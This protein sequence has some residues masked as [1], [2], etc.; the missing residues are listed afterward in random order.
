[1]IHGLGDLNKKDKEEKKKKTNDYYAGGQASGLAV[2]SP[3]VSGIVNKASKDSRPEKNEV[4]I[5]ITLFSNGF[6]VNDGPFRDY[7]APENRAFMADINQGRVPAEL[8]SMTR[9]RPVAVSLQDRRSEEYQLPPPPK[10]V[11]FSGKGESVAS[12]Q[13][14]PVGTVN[15]NAPDPPFEASLPSTTVR[16]QFHNGQRKTI[17]VNLGS[18]VQLLYEYVTFAA[19]VNGNFHL[20]SG[21]P[22]K[23]L[24]NPWAS[25]EDVGIAGS[26]VI[27]KLV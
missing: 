24:S 11:A 7:N 14:Q 15:M 25:V 26:A 17:T 27:Q 19:P 4:N 12:V 3:D 1:M 22:P 21:F 16:I 13:A 10:Y 5:T 20:V 9:G 2:S 23:P 6:Q 18:P 8:H